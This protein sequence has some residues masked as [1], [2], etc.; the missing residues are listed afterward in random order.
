[1]SCA[2]VSA[3]AFKGGKVGKLYQIT[4]T[5]IVESELVETGKP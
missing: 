1:M 5:N 2:D 4:L 3:M